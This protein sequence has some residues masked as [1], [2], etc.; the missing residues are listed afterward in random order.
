MEKEDWATRC[1]AVGTVREAWLLV[2]EIQAAAARDPNGVAGNAEVATHRALLY[3]DNYETFIYTAL[4]DGL[5]D[6]YDYVPTVCGNS[7]NVVLG[8]RNACR[9]REV[10]VLTTAVSILDGAIR[11]GR[12]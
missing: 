9:G 8:A 7:A 2:Q 1:E 3:A 5:L 10:E 4:D 12:P 6:Y 11:L